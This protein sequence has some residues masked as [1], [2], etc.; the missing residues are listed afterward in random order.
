MKTNKVIFITLIIFGLIYLFLDRNLFYYGKSD[1][2]FYDLLPLNIKPIERPDFEGGLVFE[3]RYGF[4]IVS[5]GKHKYVNCKTELIINN[6]IKYG[7]TD[8][9]FIAFVE[10]SSGSKHYIMYK[11]NDSINSKHE[12]IIS[13]IN[14]NIPINYKNIKW[15][16]LIGNIKQIRQIELLRNYVLTIIIILLLYYTISKI[17]HNRTRLKRPPNNSRS[18]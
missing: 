16:N 18:A 7:F 14:K 4:N 3:D 10:D 1:F 17:K 12:M 8:N 2:K 11:K 5:K 6:I 15:I 13:V 9:K